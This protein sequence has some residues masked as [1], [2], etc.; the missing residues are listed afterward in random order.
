MGPPGR[1][2][3]AHTA[4]DGA[5]QWEVRPWAQRDSGPA[6]GTLAYVLVLGN[7]DEARAVGL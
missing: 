3:L 7:S 6:M 4:G 2:A 5:R 1:A